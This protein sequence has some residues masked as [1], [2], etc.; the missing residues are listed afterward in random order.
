M[1]HRWLTRAVYELQLEALNVPAS[2]EEPLSDLV[3]HLLVGGALR[4][5]DT[6][7]ER[8]AADVHP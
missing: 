6:Q 2:R 5:V 7:V 3:D 4:S 8:G 1:E